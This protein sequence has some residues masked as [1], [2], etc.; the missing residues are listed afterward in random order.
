MATRSELTD[1]YQTASTRLIDSAGQ[2]AQ[3]LFLSLPD[4]RDD[5]IPAFVQQMATA[6]DASKQ[7]AANLAVAYQSEIAKLANQKF[8]SPAITA[9]DISTSVLRNGA[10]QVQ[11]YTRPFV[12]MRTALASGVDFQSALKRG[13]Y[14]AADLAKTEV[15]LA[16]RNA[17]LYARGKNKNIVGYLRVLSGAENC[18]LCSIA[19][20][21]RYH[22]RDLL[23]IHPGCDCGE[24]PIYGNQDPGQIIDEVRLERTHSGMQQAFGEFSRSGRDGIDYRTVM[25][26]EHGELGPVLTRRGQKFTSK[27]DLPETSKPVK[28]K[29][30]EPQEPKTSAAKRIREQADSIDGAAIQD[31][32]ISEHASQ[33]YVVKYNT[34]S[35]YVGGPKTQ[36]H[37]DDVQALGKTVDDEIELRVA[38]RIDEISDPKQAKP[39]LAKVEEKRSAKRKIVAEKNAYIEQ[40]VAEAKA[41]KLLENP[42]VGKRDL[43]FVERM[44]ASSAKF[45]DEYDA[46]LSKWRI[47]DNE[48]F[49]AL[50]QLEKVYPSSA[51]VA[52]IRTEET[53]KL[54]DEVRGVGQRSGTKFGFVK[55]K[56]PGFEN[57]VSHL[58]HGL[59]RYPT[60]W[61]DAASPKYSGNI[62]TGFVG[63][64]YFTKGGEIK[65]SGNRDTPDYRSDTTNTAIHELGHMMEDSVPGLRQ[66]EFAY[67]HKR[68]DGDYASWGTAKE[69]GLIDKWIRIGK[70]PYQGR[71]YLGGNPTTVTPTHSF[72]IFTTGIESTMGSSKYLEIDAYRYDT[73]TRQF[74]LGVLFGL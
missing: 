48:L 40:R 15:Q 26:Q 2:I 66:M 29:K 57:A 24:M 30:P 20:T 38:K 52:K 61:I 44:A 45:T 58:E 43:A 62:S 49:D 71:A 65:L 36:K 18:A 55:S 16:R 54:L 19:S 27:A 68:A 67:Y 70:V 28:K 47:A 60:S 8:V 1:A 74:V 4:W 14:R 37:L 23:P 5:N 56:S 39:L 42:K 11:V 59:E 73:E 13:G 32:V 17:S 41:Q 7:Q 34:K 53:L 9:D 21:Q 22:K 50:N 10:D 63:R 51:T 33:K 25:V 12:E 35:V 46:I 69:G 6:M 31:D 64:G 72:E 3:N